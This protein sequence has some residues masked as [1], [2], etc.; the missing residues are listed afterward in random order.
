MII[1]IK[2]GWLNSKTNI[3]QKLTLHMIHREEERPKLI[4][5]IIKQII[6]D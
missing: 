6:Q 5:Y 3:I 1:K 4:N 2:L